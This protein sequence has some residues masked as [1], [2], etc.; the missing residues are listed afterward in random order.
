MEIAAKREKALTLLTES[1]VLCDSKAVEEAITRL[2]REI[3]ESLENQFPI[4]CCVMNGGVVLAG[5]L[6]SRLV[7]PLDFDYIDVSRYS[8]ENI[9]GKLIWRS[10]P[11]ISLKNRVVLLVDDIL[12]E[13]ET[14]AQVKK[15]FLEKGAS[16]VYIAVMADKEIGHEKPVVADFVGLTL[17]NRFVF[18]FGMDASGFWRNLPAIYGI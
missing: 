15:K 8:T 17:P 14:L 16:S 5:H 10:K 18:G 6:M 1:E 2:S 11:R 9:A 12:D 3:T 7:F 4:L 13:G